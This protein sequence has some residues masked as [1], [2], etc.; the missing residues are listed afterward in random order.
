MKAVSKPE[1]KPNVTERVC[2]GCNKI[3]PLR[4][5]VTATSYSELCEKCRKRGK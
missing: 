2:P 5:F 4:L 1:P 3:L